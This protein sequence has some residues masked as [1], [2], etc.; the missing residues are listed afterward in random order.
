MLIPDA[1]GI[2]Q[3]GGDYGGGRSR[4]VFLGAA[5]VRWKGPPPLTA[6]CDDTVPVPPGL[7]YLNVSKITP[8]KA[9]TSWTPVSPA[10][11]RF[12]LLP[13]FQ[14]P[15]QLLGDLLQRRPRQTQ[16]FAMHPRKDPE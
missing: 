15:V 7:C 16:Q 3:T 14:A 4:R 6:P 11:Q 13:P 1:L 5:C 10:P 9:F 8:A 12:Q 2:P